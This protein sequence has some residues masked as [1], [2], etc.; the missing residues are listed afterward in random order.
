MGELII[1]RN[2]TFA[3]PQYQ[4]T[5]KA[6]KTASAGQSQPAAQGAVEPKVSE[7]LQ[8]MTN[9]ISQ[10]ENDIRAG[11]QT[12]Q[13]GQGMLDELQD[14]LSRLAELARKAAEG[15]ASDQ[16]ALQGELEQLQ[17]EINRIIRSAAVDGTPLFL[18]N[19]SSIRDAGQL[20]VW[21][22][23]KAEAGISPD[24]A[25]Q[26]LTG[27]AIESIQQL[28]ELLAGG[29]GIGIRETLIDLMMTSGGAALL[30]LLAGMEG[31]NMD[32]LLSLMANLQTTDAQPPP[33]AAPASPQP[34]P[35]PQAAP[36]PTLELGSV[37]VSGSDLS[38]VSFDRESGELTISGGTDMTVQGTGQDIQ[39]I[40]LAGSGA[41]TFRN[42][43][44]GELIVE[45]SNVQVVTEGQNQLDGVRLEKGSV[46]TLTGE[47]R[48]ELGTVRGDA[49]S[50]L[51]LT[52]GAVIVRGE[53]GETLGTVT[54]PVVLEG[55]AAF[56]AR[57]VSVT[58]AAGQRQEPFDLIWKT[59][60][61]GWDGLTSL[62]VDGK[63]GK[64]ALL[65]GDPARLWL[66]RGD[67]GFPAH[68]LVLQ[69]QEKPGRIQ[70]RYA[71]LQWNKQRERFEEVPMYPNPF[72]VTG[73]EAEQD[74]VY[75]EE[76]Q[77]L[78]IL[79]S[80]VTAISG[81]TGTDANQLPFSG[82]IALASGIGT[83]ELALEGVVC[84]V[85]SGRA[86]DLGE[87][88]QV[89]LVLPGGVSNLF[90][91]GAGCAGITLGEGTLLCVDCVQPQEEDEEAAGTL[92]AAGG[93]GCAGI[94]RDGVAGWDPAD[95]VV[96]RG[97]EGEEDHNF[98][99]PVT[100]SG[101]TVLPVEAE[102]DGQAGCIPLQVG[103][104]TVILP[105][106][107]LSVR[108][109]ELN[110]MSLMTREYAR[111]AQAVLEADRRRVAQMQ[112]VYSVLYDWLNQGARGLPEMR[113][114]PAQALVRS[115]GQADTLLEDMR[116]S[117]LLQP[118]QAMRTHNR[119]DAKGA[120]ELL[121]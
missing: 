111:D 53:K 56:S 98:L 3:P 19:G 27:G 50:T 43:T 108:A 60:L 42:V 41:V 116:R 94:G 40:R 118:A 22:M 75:E 82:R 10:M 6:G 4:S 52:G 119:R 66:T 80:Q 71:Y 78:H 39:T 58:N 62:A 96:I 106:F 2:R 113:F 92:T 16:D 74:W 83:I 91:S 103:E 68:S 105:Q 97:A 51:S 17:G 88:N 86:F 104:E 102:E 24:Q 8:K 107:T 20:L 31:G 15:G 9:Q 21:L 59:L 121:K 120:H 69:N 90:A 77:T 29:M 54:I 89:T 95:P 79:S 14:N 84:Q 64:L 23:N 37:R 11:R 33:E 109:L 93:L 5:A 25:I 32:L 46:L 73:G 1:R 34:E 117:I 61:P 55:T 63:Q 85:L 81:G 18:G 99:G 72:V 70:T 49:S 36:L 45:N 100:I 38:G 44:G 112:E 110:G 87:E 57:A 67:Q 7:T 28:Q 35:Q 114:T 65:Q 47:G 101:G 12:V 76:T 115:P 30:K 13:K 26:E 48:L